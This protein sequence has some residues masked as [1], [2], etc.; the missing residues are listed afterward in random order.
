MSSFGSSLTTISTQLS[1]ASSLERMKEQQQQNRERLLAEQQLREG[2]ESTFERKMQSALVSP[3]QRV[4]AP[5][6]GI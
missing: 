5:A 4:A 6:Q 3:M 1:E 2:K